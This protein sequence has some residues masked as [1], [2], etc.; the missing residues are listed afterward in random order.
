VGAKLV[1]V[2]GLIADAEAQSRAAAEELVRSIPKQSGIEIS[3]SSVITTLASLDDTMSDLARCHDVSLVLLDSK[4]DDKCTLA[5][6]L[7]FGSGRPV[8][9]LPE[10][11]SRVGQLNKIAVAWD[12]GRAA[13]R[14]ISDAM[15]LISRAEQ[16]TVLASSED[17]QI[18]AGSVPALMAYLAR[19]GVKASSQTVE[20]QTADIGIAL[21]RA[22][23][24]SDAGL[25]VMGA[26]G[27]NRLREFVLGGATRS[28]IDDLRMPILMSH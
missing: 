1:N 3:H 15:P 26:F 22:A 2:A 23:V 27:H 5:E 6:A 11:F 8:M 13:A 28:V 16:V 14:S 10:S 17:K 20:L 18:D 7:M 9:L 19:H 24:A 12:G 21:Q 4:S 25:L